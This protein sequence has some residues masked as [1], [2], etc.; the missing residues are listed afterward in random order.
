MKMIPVY[1]VEALK[2]R[3]IAAESQ[4]IISE[5]IRRCCPH[6]LALI[7]Q[8]EFHMIYL[9]LEDINLFG[10]TYT[11]VRG[12]ATHIDGAAHILEEADRGPPAGD[13]RRTSLSIYCINPGECYNGA[14]EIPMYDPPSDVPR[15][16][17]LQAGVRTTPRPPSG[18]DPAPPDPTDLGTHYPEPALDAIE[19]ADRH[20]AQAQATLRPDPALRVGPALRA[21]PTLSHLDA[22]FRRCWQDG[23]GFESGGG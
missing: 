3:L 8:E 23:D 14:A 2:R 17:P 9:V 4:L 12:A 20:R 11:E 15:S 18:P 6:L 5:R 1:K 7:R 10:V 22:A 21:N 16:E 19:R 13:G